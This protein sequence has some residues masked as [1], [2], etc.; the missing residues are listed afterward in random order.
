[1][2]QYFSKQPL[3]TNPEPFSEVKDPALT[4]GLFWA[5]LLT[6]RPLFLLGGLWLAL[7][8]VSAIA[9]HWLMFN[10]PIEDAAYSE[11]PLTVVDALPQALPS[12]SSRLPTGNTAPAN[13]A[14][15]VSNAS[16]RSGP[17]TLW[18]L[19]SLVGLCGF[20]CFVLA[21]QIRASARPTKRKKPRPR[22]VVKSAAPVLPPQPKRLAPYSPQ[23]DGFVV[24]GVRI[25]EAPA[26]RLSL[27]N[28]PVRPLSANEPQVVARA[29]P[30]P[31]RP[32]QPQVVA[33]ALVPSHHPAVVP[34]EADLS[35]DW[36]EGSVAHAL[37]MRQR[38]SLSS[39][40]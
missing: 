10:E 11:A 25:I 9:Y 31:D 18:V 37:D 40:M 27:K 35:L 14:A 34:D 7:V 5:R 36:P 19:F 21:Q 39:F 12:A 17:V 1:M 26:P 4:S 2:A 6:Y 23:R 15:P 20:G 8:C 30:R 33:A 22:P 38:R 13:A 29:M 32:S 24:P 3:R 28:S 16:S